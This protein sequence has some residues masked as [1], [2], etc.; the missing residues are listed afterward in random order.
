MQQT[1]SKG[2]YGHWVVL[3]TI[4]VSCI[5]VLTVMDITMSPGD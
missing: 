2:K 4:I 1:L 3:A 5:I